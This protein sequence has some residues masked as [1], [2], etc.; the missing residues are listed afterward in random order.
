[1]KR[2]HATSLMA[3]GVLG[4]AV[5]FLLETALVGT[6]SPLL[7]PPLA[8]PVT[9]IA[10]GVIVVLLALPVRRAVHA[11]VKTHIDPF[12]AMRVAVLAK[13]CSLTGSLLGGVGVGML[14]Y[15]L[16]RSVLPGSASVWLTAAVAFGGIALMI[17]GLIAEFFCTLPPPSD[18]DETSADQAPAR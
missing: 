7:I 10:I 16:T 18:E 8:L 15:V 11:D 9:L 2:T 1:M 4:L 17:G 12:R 6:G 3:I 13:A 5:G 14:I